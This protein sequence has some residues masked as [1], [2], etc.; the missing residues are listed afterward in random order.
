MY[1]KRLD[2]KDQ[3]S[4]KIHDVTTCLTNNAIHT[5]PNISRSKGN[6]AMQFGH[7]I[8]YNIFVEKSYTK[9][10]GETVPK[11]LSKKSKLSISLDQ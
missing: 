9:C 11:P 4:F 2:L 10:A 7:L 5:L 3:D 6:Q 8:E 1:K